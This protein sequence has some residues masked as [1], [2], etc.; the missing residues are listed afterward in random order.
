M[1]YSPGITLG[2]FCEWFYLSCKLILWNWYVN[3]FLREYAALRV[4]VWGVQGECDSAVGV[5]FQS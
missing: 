5:D 1:D 3:F 4:R 2:I